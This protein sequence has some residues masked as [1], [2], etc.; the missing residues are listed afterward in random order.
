MKNPLL[1]IFATVLLDAMGLG[2]MMPILPVLLRS[3][4]GASGSSMHYGAMLAVY[5]L[6]QFLF[7]PILGALSDRFGRRPVLLVSL[8]AAAVDYLLMAGA[9]TLGWLYV[10]RVLAGITGASAAVATAYVTDITPQADRA[11]RFG[12]MGAVMGLGFIFG[13]LLGGLLGEWHLRAP[14]VAAAVVNALNLGMAL[15]VLPESR[16]QNADAVRER[17]NLNA[18]AALHRLDGSAALLPLAGVFAVIVLVSQAPATL[19]I[20]YGQYRFGWSTMI[21]GASLAAFGACHFVTQAFLTGPVVAR[22][23]ERAAMLAGIAADALALLLMGGA[24]RGWMPFALVPLFAV[25]GMA[26]PAL[27]ASLSAQVDE[28]RQGEL[29]G[30]LASIA[31]LIGVVGPL[32]VIAGFAATRVTHPGLMWALSAALYLLVL[33]LMFNARMRSLY[34]STSPV[35]DAS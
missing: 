26:I 33:P 18:F 16:P 32:V 30:T 19:W 7:A 25:G 5:A 28:S 4:A 24:T 3:F 29:Q 35:A 23:G 12:Q 21:A 15:F 1:V 17:P 27:Q 20:V 22:L 10:G 31:S 11:S 2:L 13:P 34:A 8:A 9:P 14:F 6:M